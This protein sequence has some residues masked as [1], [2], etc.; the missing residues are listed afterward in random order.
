TAFGDD[1]VSERTIQRW[2]NK[3]RNV[4]LDLANASRDHAAPAIDNDELRTLVECD[5]RQTV[6]DIAKTLGVHYS[7][8]S[9]HLQALG[10]VK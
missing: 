10:K 4:N 8:V 7:T 1:T 6:R 9:R 5:P 2:F 3:F